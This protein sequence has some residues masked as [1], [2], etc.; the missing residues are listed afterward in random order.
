MYASL[1]F[2][3]NIEKYFVKHTEKLLVYI[4]MPRLKNKFNLIRIYHRGKMQQEIKARS[5]ENI[6]LYYLLWF[7]Y[8]WYILLNFFSFNEKFYVLVGHP[9]S[10][11]G[12]TFQRLVRRNAKFMY[13]I[14]DY[15]PQGGIAIQLF[16]KVKKHYHGRVDFVSYLS[17]GINKVF[18]NGKVVSA[19]NK[20]TVMWG[21][22]PKNV[23]RNFPKDAFTILF[24]GL[25]KDSQ[26]LE[27]MFDFLKKHKDY[28]LNIIGI[29]DDKLYESYIKTIRRL[30][31]SSQVYF[32]NQ[33]FSDEDLK[34]ISK[35]CHIGVAL[36]NVDKS[37]PTYYTDPGKV[38]AYAEMLLPVI[39]SDTSGI[40]S[41]VKKFRSG[42]VIDQSPSDLA[43]AF[44]EI[45]NNY[46]EYI[47]GLNKFNKYFY[48]EEYYRK[49]FKF[50][51]R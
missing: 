7:Y 45:K 46:Q 29:C 28:K 1:Q 16:E 35:K 25:I 22:E 47:L 10:L 26:G 20:K 23:Q 41:F 51:E 30:G 17:D 14:G 8:H 44:R 4:V 49:A 3:G 33:F 11:F 12:L 5:S 24:I 36:Y 21:V 9:V 32:P 15:F 13:W 48:Y 18:N 42:I 40:A 34:E 39:M 27:F 6:F 31:I 19:N 38:K 50:L 43:K 37:N 2:C